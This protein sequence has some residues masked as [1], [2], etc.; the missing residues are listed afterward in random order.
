[1]VS[2]LVDTDSLIDVRLHSI[3]YAARDTNLY[4]FRPIAGGRL[5]AG[6]PG[7]HIDL[8]LP[9]GLTRQYSLTIPDESP[10]A[11]VLGI[12]RDADSR[13]GSKFIFDQVKV[14]HEL[15]I[16]RPRNNFPLNEN[17]AHTVL[18]AGGIGITPIWAMVQRLVAL[19]RSWELHYS[20]RS[21]A[22]AAFLDALTG[23]SEARL[24]FDDEHAG[25]FL[26]LGAIVTAASSDAHLYCCGPAPMLEAFERAAA[27]ISPE[28]RHVE[29]FTPRETAK[30]EGGFIVQLARSGR[31]V[32]IPPGK[33]ILEAL[34]SAG[35]TIP[36]SCEEGICGACETKVL[37][38]IPDHRDS[39]LTQ[40]DR[41]A[42]K[43]MM[44]CTSGS[45]SE[46]LVL[47]L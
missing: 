11:Y 14:G 13:G 7:A 27:G 28:R 18:L 35:L 43:S 20:C 44:I 17:A 23:R 41:A 16:S 34:R 40:A 32:V 22:E 24:H 15:K 30:P 25:A 1:M 36:S 3:H 4:E 8:H 9:N 45:K 5:P 29:Y 6:S 21:R 10:Q 33:S 39:V 38:G 42:N 26:D 37:S 47:D 2:G 31:E 19:G 46:K 12:K